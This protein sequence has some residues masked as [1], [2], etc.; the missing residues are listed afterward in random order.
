VRHKKAVVMLGPSLT[1]KGGIA[2]VASSYQQ[3]GFFERY[4]IIYVPT[5]VEGS[6]LRKYVTTL[7]AISVVIYLICRRRV[8]LFHIHVARWNS[9]WRKALFM[10]IAR[11]C[12]VPYIIHIHAGGFPDFY[13]H[14]CSSFGKWIIRDFIVSASQVV[15]LTSQLKSWARSAGAKQITLLPNFVVQDENKDSKAQALPGRI[16]FLGRLTAE[17]GVFD[18]LEVAY[19]LEQEGLSFSINLAGE[20]NVKQVKERINTLSLQ[21][22]IDLPGWL[23][24]ADKARALD[25]A[26]I[27]VLPSYVECLPMGILEAM[28]AGLAVVATNVGGIPD[29]IVHEKTG[30][31]FEPG[32]LG[33]LARA[34]K[35]LLSDGRK[36]NELGAAAMSDFLNKYSL[37]NI[38]ADY[39]ELYSFVAT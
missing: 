31:L 32:D 7:K 37:E 27:F 34:L 8:S 2:S 36:R 20:G 17:K 19:Q 39:D 23:S 33:A 26:E 5:Q 1:S 10:A 14:D 16:L 13:N 29:Q 25:E 15:V 38:I 21:D 28:K 12:R 11:L 18:L 9:F 30:L 3:A 4:S 22:K 35:V 24:G 6:K